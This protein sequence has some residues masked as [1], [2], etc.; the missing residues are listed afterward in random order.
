MRK[1]RRDAVDSG[2]IGRH[3]EKENDVQSNPLPSSL[4]EVS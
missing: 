4:K 1:E 3:V 2:C